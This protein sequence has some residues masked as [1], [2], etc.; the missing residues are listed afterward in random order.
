MTSSA[1]MHERHF[2]DI[3]LEIWE[4]ASSDARLFC[5]ADTRTC[6][7]YARNLSLD[8]SRSA[9]NSKNTLLSLWAYS[10]EYMYSWRNIAGMIA[11]VKP[12]RSNARNT[13]IQ[14]TV[15]LARVSLEEE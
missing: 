10:S 11:I 9:I 4:E 2:L 14:N 1:V 6:P 7:L 15:Y 8:S 3:F 12:L 5:I 13:E